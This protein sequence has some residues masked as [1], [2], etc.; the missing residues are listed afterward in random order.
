MI[1]NNCDNTTI[2]STLFIA[3]NNEIE[4]QINS[5]RNKIEVLLKKYFFK[6]YPF[7]TKKNKANVFKK[8]RYNH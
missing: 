2:D 1:A 4:D 6:G 3:K 8:F 7:I 5:A